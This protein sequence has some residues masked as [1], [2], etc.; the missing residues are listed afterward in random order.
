[1]NYIKNGNWVRYQNGNYFVSINLDNGTKIRETI[2][3]DATE[4]VADFPESADVKIT[5]KC[6]YNCTFCFVPDTL[7][8]VEKDQYKNIQDCKV[9]D[10]VLSFNLNTSKQETKQINKIYKHHYKGQLNIISVNG[11]E[12]KCTPNHKIYVKN[13]GYIEAKDIKAGDE[14]LCM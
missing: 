10:K 6:P 2:N 7:V 12:L 11:I 14:I 8:A 4:F 3:P 1:M 9:G 5:N 13:K